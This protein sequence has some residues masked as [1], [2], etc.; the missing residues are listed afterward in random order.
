MGGTIEAVQGYVFQGECVITAPAKG[1][2]ALYAF[3]WNESQAAVVIA[4]F[5]RCGCPGVQLV[6]DQDDTGKARLSKHVATVLAALKLLAT[7]APVVVSAPGEEHFRYTI[8]GHVVT[9]T[10][11]LE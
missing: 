10:R 9:F 4:N 7:S 2:P 11:T 1:V 6:F 5:L 3:S 8:G